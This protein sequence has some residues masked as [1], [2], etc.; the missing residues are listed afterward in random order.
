MAKRQVQNLVDALAERLGR[1]VVLDD[2]EVN[3]LV[4]SRH[5][6]DADEQRI[7]AVLQR[8]VGTAAIGHILGQDVA[9]WTSPG[10]VPAREDLG[11]KSRL[12]HP[13]RRQGQLLGLLLV[14]D[15]DQSMTPEEIEEVV[16][17][18]DDIGA[19]LYGELLSQDE[20]RHE[21]ET[22]VVELLTGDTARPETA[23]RTLDR[24]G[25]LRHGAHVT[26]TAVTLDDRAVAVETAVAELA[27]RV[28][29]VSASRSRP[30]YTASAVL[31]TRGVLLQTWENG[32][33]G[34]RLR[35]QATELRDAVGSVL[36]HSAGA[37]AG[38]GGVHAGLHEAHRAY[39]EALVAL[40]AALRVARLDGLA[41]ADELGAL[42]LVLRLPETELT[43]ARVPE[44][45]RRLRCQDPHGQLLQTLRCF[46]D[47]AGSRPATAEALHIHRTTLYYRLDRIEQITGLS[48]DDG[49][50]RLLLHLG[51][52]VLEVVG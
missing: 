13:I 33:T 44:P 39:D 10:V 28:A 22:A 34:E 49:S 18:G 8:D 15:E 26:V 47:L 17:T 5:Y 4:A 23:V 9:H 35:E 45:L 3:L 16:R 11:M 27:L 21:Q 38:V 25:V 42:D 37:I 52:Q 29:T 14:I 41:L 30:G 43:P 32:P 48:L 19:I 1:S 12:C 20:H 7:R 40:R 36:G 46:L 50:T 51:L 6:G 31:G 24:L 2:T